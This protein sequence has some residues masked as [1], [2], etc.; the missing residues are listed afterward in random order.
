MNR[1]QAISAFWV[2]Y[3]DR[4]KRAGVP[5]QLHSYYAGHVDRFIRYKG[6]VQ[7][8]E[9]TP[10]LVY[11]YLDEQAVHPTCPSWRHEQL[12]TALEILFVDL[13]QADWAR[14]FDWHHWKESGYK[15][16]AT[17]AA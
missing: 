9:T 15:R 5:E 11:R 13:V 12:V 14:R 3:V 10:S 7:L 8:R 6:A 4:L 1:Q 16:S 17:Q 2:R